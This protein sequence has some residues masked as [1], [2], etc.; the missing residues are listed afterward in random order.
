MKNFNGCSGPMGFA[1]LVATVGIFAFGY[2][3]MSYI[4]KHMGS[5]GVLLFMGIFI[6][7]PLLIVVL[8]LACLFA[9]GIAKIYAGAA[10]SNDGSLQSML[11]V[12]GQMIGLAK[13][14]GRVPNEPSAPME[15]WNVLPPPIDDPVKRLTDHSGW[16]NGSTKAKVGQ[17][18]LIEG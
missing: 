13:G 3:G 6:G 8:I 14:G 9:L 18:M 7:I 17:N 16:E 5:N 12:Y 11:K 10:Q 15:G 4:D 1:V 2:L